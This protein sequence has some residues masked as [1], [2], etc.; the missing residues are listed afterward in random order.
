MQG[1]YIAEWAPRHIVVVEAWVDPGRQPA[2][3]SVEQREVL[4]AE[5]RG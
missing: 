5:K 2:R 1:N 3:T 4:Y